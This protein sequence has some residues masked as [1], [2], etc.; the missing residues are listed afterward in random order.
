M[1]AVNY[2]ASSYAVRDDLVAAQQLAW[3]RISEPGAWLDGRLRIAVAEEVRHAP[4]CGLCLRR[5]E[6]LS[7][8]AINGQHDG[9]GTLREV[10]VDVV[11][12]I[13]TD[14]GRLSRAWLERCLETGLSEE[15]YIE[16]VSVICMVLIVDTFTRALGLPPFP[17]PEPQDG[18]PSRYRAP[19]ARMHDAWISHLEPQD[20]VPEDGKVYDGPTAAAVVTAL[21][22]VPDAKRAY[23]DLADFHYLPNSEI[24]NFGTEIRAIDRMQIEVIAARVSALHQCVY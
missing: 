5:K 22:L 16:I 24:F 10:E 15:E 1:H 7:P 4:S 14:P 12:R 23:W 8:F 21:S 17:L 13:A 20:A 19:G 3:K 2:D 9:P 18:E 6:A 11:H